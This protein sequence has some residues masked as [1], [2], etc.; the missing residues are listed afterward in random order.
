[1]KK[2]SLLIIIFLSGFHTISQAVE[3]EARLSWVG[4]QKYGFSVNGVV[5]KV[6]VKVGEK[7]KK[8]D[9][10]A[11]LESNPFNYKIK[12]C[13]AQ[14]DKLNPQI[15][16]AKLELDQA[17]ELFERTVLSEVELQKIDGK[18]KVLIES[19]KEVKAECLLRSWKL[20]R[21]A[22]K[23]RD[24]AYVVNSNVIEAMVIS[25]ENKTETFIE[26]VSAKQASAVAFLTY[27]QKLKFNIGQELK[28]VV[29]QQEFSAKVES[30]DIQPDKENKYKLVSVFYYTK[31]VEPDKVV[32]LKY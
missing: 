20:K 32:K 21:S 2:C 28:V 7:V 6:L 8:G 30:I 22:L 4:H 25:A 13:Q 15:F 17:E 9:A 18:Y 27:Q 1:M 12:Q 26:L 23:A 19:Q 3:M 16:D 31:M 29:D 24:S 5:D 11:K 10:L 14:F